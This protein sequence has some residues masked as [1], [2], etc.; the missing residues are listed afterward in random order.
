MNGTGWMRATGEPTAWA[1]R[2][3]IEREQW[4]EHWLLYE[5]DLQIQED[6]EW[7]VEAVCQFDQVR[8]DRLRSGAMTGFGVTSV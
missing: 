8:L 3:Q 7:F 1:N 2:F 5:R 4:S 6:M